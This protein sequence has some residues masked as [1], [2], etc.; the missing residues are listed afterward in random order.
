MPSQGQSHRA[1]LYFCGDCRSRFSVTVGT[2]FERSKIP[3]HKWMLA[4]HLMCSSKRGISGHQHRTVGVTYKPQF[5][6]LRIR[7]ALG[8]ARSVGSG[9]GPVDG[10]ADWVRKRNAQGQP[11]A[12]T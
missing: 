8:Q 7:E 11:V 4:T 6:T 9:G 2:V 12:Q 10:S 3:L 5:M 1:G